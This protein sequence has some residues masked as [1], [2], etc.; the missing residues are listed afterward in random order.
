MEYFSA[1]VSGKSGASFNRDW[2]SKTS[3]LFFPRCG[4]IYLSASTKNLSAKNLQ[5]GVF[6]EK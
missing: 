4:Y 3:Y 5:V 2:R 6:V 1:V